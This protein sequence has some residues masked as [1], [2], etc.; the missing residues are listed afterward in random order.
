MLSSNS[1][2]LRGGANLLFGEEFSRLGCNS[3]GSGTKLL[4]ENGKK[5]NLESLP[6]SLTRSGKKPA[7]K[8]RQTSCC[9]NLIYREVTDRHLAKVLPQE[10]F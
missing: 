3:S 8:R 5:K 9:S 2:K 1:C 6:G 7:T 10:I 4:Q